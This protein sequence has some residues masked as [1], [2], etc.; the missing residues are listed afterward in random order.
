M[1]KFWHY[2]LL[3]FT[4][5]YNFTPSSLRMPRRRNTNE[6]WLRISE[7]FQASYKQIA[8]K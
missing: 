3:G 5:C 4:S 8:E 7:Y 2:F 1:N 6:Y